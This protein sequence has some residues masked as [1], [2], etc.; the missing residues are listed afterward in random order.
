MRFTVSGR[1]FD[2]LAANFA[3][4][5][6]GVNLSDGSISRN[7]S[8]AQFA[9]SVGLHDWR[10]QPQEPLS[11]TVTIRSGDLADAFALAGEN[12]SGTRGELTANAHIS[13]TIDNPQGAIRASV[14]DGTIRHEPFNRI[15]MPP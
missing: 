15:L 3:A 13:G 11:A 10:T 6:S 7:S 8:M 5:P 2:R 9:A 4:S 14:V 12:P 1:P